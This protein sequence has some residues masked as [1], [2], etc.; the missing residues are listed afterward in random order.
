M[1]VLA[2]DTATPAGSSAVVR[3]GVV[4]AER[5]GDARRT[6]GERLPRELMDALDAAG[7]SL[8]QIDA[9]GVATGPGSFTGLRVG[10]AT[11]QGLA[12][13]RGARV[14]PVSNF[15]AHARRTPPSPERLGIWLDAHRGEVFAT[16]RDI[17]RRHVLE[18]PTSL[19][20]AATLDQWS[21]SIAAG[22]RIRF[23]GDA[24]RRYANFLS[25]RLGAAAIIDP[26]VPLL[27]GVIG[28]IACGDPSGTVLPHAIVPLYVRRPD[29]ELARERA[30]PLEQKP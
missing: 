23:V 19:T 30:R 1:V 22:G 4:L 8:D 29:A 15:E 2:L 18:P 5:G 27:S 16:L 17:D 7:L 26:A 28:Q 9:Y 11:I 12:L 21:R 20:P 25:D 3:D 14:M 10:I 6:H 24:V 13:S